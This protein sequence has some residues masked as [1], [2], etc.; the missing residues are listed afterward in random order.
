MQICTDSSVL[1]QRERENKADKHF[2]G[3][4]RAGF[5]E[6]IDAEP[7]NASMHHCRI[8]WR[9]FG[10]FLT[11]NLRREITKKGNLLR[12]VGPKF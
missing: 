5:G 4:Q 3:R 12:V 10:G 6:E 7:S 1:R 8:D 11:D 2:C 9:R